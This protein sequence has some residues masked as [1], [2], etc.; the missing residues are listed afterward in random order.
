MSK[1]GFASLG[2]LL[3]PPIAVI[4]FPKL[5]AARLWLLLLGFILLVLTFLRAALRRHLLGP[6]AQ[7]VAPREFMAMTFSRNELRWRNSARLLR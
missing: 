5:G 7:W 4:T 1:E 3:V 6:F 2:I